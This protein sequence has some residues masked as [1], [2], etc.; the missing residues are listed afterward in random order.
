[1]NVLICGGGKE[2]T[3]VIN[4]FKGSKNLLRVINGDEKI[5][6]TIS[7]INQIDVI[8]SDPTKFFSFEV[9]DVLNF[10]LVIALTDSDADNFII[11][12][13]AK[14]FFHI[15]KAICT[16]S[17]PELVDVFKDLG[18]DTPIS[19]RYLLSQKIKGESDIESIMSSF[20]LEDNQVLIS[21]ITIK[22]DFDCI[23]MALKD[24]NLPITGNITCIYR[25]PKVIIP[26]GDTTINC[27]DHIYICS[28]PKD[29]D[30]LVEFITKRKKKDDE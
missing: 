7:E 23:G 29:Q 2:T 3:Y 12:K 9:A 13:I 22:E 24:L 8:N 15:K 14:D 25:E 6:N 5:S 30:E 20:V 28:S 1:M 19:A 4:S 16:I 27:N 21:E 26:R 11:C 17:N 18:I 10:D